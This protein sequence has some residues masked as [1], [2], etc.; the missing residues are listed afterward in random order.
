VTGGGG[1]ARDTENWGEPVV[2]EG[3]VTVGGGG[4]LWD[5]NAGEMCKG[6]FVKGVIDGWLLCPLTSICV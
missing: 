3:V 5:A 4:D 6:P 1:G 2:P